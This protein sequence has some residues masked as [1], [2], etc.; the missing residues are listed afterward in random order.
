MEDSSRQRRLLITNS[1]FGVLCL[2]SS[3]EG[4]IVWREEADTH[5]QSKKQPNIL[6]AP[7]VCETSTAQ[8]L[9]QERSAHSIGCHRSSSSES[10][11]RAVHVLLQ[12]MGPGGKTDFYHTKALASPTHRAQATAAQESNLIFGTFERTAC[13]VLTF[14]NPTCL[15]CHV[16]RAR[17]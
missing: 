16:M 9:Q 15:T 17:A 6:R 10:L 12:V 7:S 8:P 11:P 13:A 14:L 4:Q 1:T 2:G 5:Q 3:C